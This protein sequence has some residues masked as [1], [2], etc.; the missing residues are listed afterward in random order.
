MSC[1]LLLILLFQQSDVTAGPGPE[2]IPKVAQTPATPEVAVPVDPSVNFDLPDSLQFGV[3]DLVL[4]GKIDSDWAVFDAEPGLEDAAGKFG[5]GAILRRARIGV[6]GPLEDWA[7]LKLSADL[8]AAEIRDA[9]VDIRGLLGDGVFRVGRFREPMGL[10][11]QTPSQNQTF[12]ERPMASGL[13]PS[14]NLGMMWRNNFDE[15]RAALNVGIFR[16]SDERGVSFDETA[17]NELA[18]TGRLTWL[19]HEAKQG[20]QF[21]HL[22][23]SFSWRNPDAGQVDY[24]AGPGTKIGTDLLATGSLPAEEVVLFGFEAAWRDG[25]YTLSG[26]YNYA[27]FFQ[28]DGVS[29]G[30][31]GWYFEA[32]RFLTGESRPYK[33]G[34]AAFWQVNPAADFDPNSDGLGAFEVGFRASRLD[35][36]DEGV[37]GGD[38]LNLGVA[39]NWYLSSQVRFQSNFFLADRVEEGDTFVVAFR[40]HIEF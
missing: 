34:R 17:G 7:N 19:A 4:F 8:G 32:S 26:E 27:G 29:P 9:Y 5:N 3:S 21:L 30:M 18:L 11:N 31:K 23:T 40:F 10:S 6:K 38:A 35:L 33:R 2:D 25:P 20:E 12:M 22:G 14:R 13:F 36:Q 16:A 15:D 24:S 1:T 28:A 37:F 39:F